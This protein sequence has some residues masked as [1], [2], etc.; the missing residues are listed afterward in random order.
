MKDGNTY[1]KRD[2]IVAVCCVVFLTFSLGVIGD[3]ARQR[4]KEALCLSNLHQWGQMYSLFAKDN[5]GKLMGWNEYDWYTFGPDP[6]DRFVEHA[7]VYMMYPYYESF[8]MCLCPAATNLW[9][10][11][12]TFSAPYAAWDFEYFF[13]VEPPMWEWFSYYIVDGKPAYGSYGK[14]EWITDGMG[15]GAGDPFFRTI[16]VSGTSNIPLKGD[17][18]WMA[19]FP[20]PWD[21]PAV[22]RLHFP[23]CGCGGE[24]NRW[25]VDRH[26]KAIN[27]LFLDWSARK[28]GLRQ[29]WTLKWN[30]DTYEGESVWGNLIIIPDP[31]DPEDWPEW[32]R[33]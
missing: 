17:S 24:I 16:Y 28:V 2:L 22:T 29:L 33:D 31:D 30:R 1:T 32:M 10:E 8:D 21:E 4:A 15:W 9:T 6:D 18:T 11:S 7:W 3:G 19:G 26:G 20:T 14:N 12:S 13:D 25:N 27:M 5:D 23:I